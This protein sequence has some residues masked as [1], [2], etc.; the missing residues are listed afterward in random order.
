MHQIFKIIRYRLC[1]DRACRCS[2]KAYDSES[3]GPVFDPGWQHPAVALTRHFYSLNYWL[4]HR[5]RWLRSDM[6]EKLLTWTLN[7]NTN[8]LVRV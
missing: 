1:N 5:K 4:M 2:G 7:L 3:R 8:E 6:T